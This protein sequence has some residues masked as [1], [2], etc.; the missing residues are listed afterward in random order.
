MHTFPALNTRAVYMQ[1]NTSAISPTKLSDNPRTIENVSN[2]T[3]ER[4]LPIQTETSLKGSKETRIFNASSNLP[5]YNA[6][7]SSE[8]LTTKFKKEILG[9]SLDI[10]Y[11]LPKPLNTVFAPITLESFLKT[12]A[13]VIKNKFS[14]DISRINIKGNAIRELAGFDYF[15]TLLKEQNVVLDTLLT[16]EELKAVRNTFEIKAPRSIEVVVYLRKNENKKEVLQKLQDLN[17]SIFQMLF[18]SLKTHWETIETPEIRASLFE[19]LK[20]KNSKFEYFDSSKPIFF[21]LIIENFAFSHYETQ[22]G[23]TPLSQIGFSNPGF[24]LKVQTVFTNETICQTPEDFYQASIYVSS[25]SSSDTKVAFVTPLQKRFDV[26]QCFLGKVIP[27]FDIKEVIYLWGHFIA[28]LQKGYIPAPDLDLPGLRNKTLNPLSDSLKQNKFV[29]IKPE[30]IQ[31]KTLIDHLRSTCPE[32]KNPKKALLLAIQT[33]FMEN[34]TLTEAEKKMVLSILSVH[35]TNHSLN[36]ASVWKIFSN[37]LSDPSFTFATFSSTLQITHLILWLTQQKK[38]QLHGIKNLWLDSTFAGEQ[39]EPLHLLHAFDPIQAFDSLLKSVQNESSSQKAFHSLLLALHTHRIKEY[40]SKTDVLPYDQ[41]QKNSVENTFKSLLK[42]INKGIYSSSELIF[43]LSYDLLLAVQR[44]KVVKSD[45]II[46]IENFEKR[47]ISSTESSSQFV[48]QELFECFKKSTWDL[49]EEDLKS[50]FDILQKNTTEENFKKSI[51]QWMNALSKLR[52]GD[53]DK[54]LFQLWSKDTPFE[55]EFSKELFNQFCL[56]DPDLAYAMLHKLLKKPLEVQEQVELILFFTKHL[57]GSTDAHIMRHLLFLDSLCER[58]RDVWALFLDKIDNDLWKWFLEQKN[59]KTELKQTLI[60]LNQRFLKNASPKTL[61]QK[62]R[63]LIE[64]YTSESNLPEALKC[65]EFLNCPS[66]HDQ[67]EPFNEFFQHLSIQLYQER[68]GCL[69]AKEPYPNLLN[70]LE[71][72]HVETLKSK[73]LK[74]VLVDLKQGSGQFLSEENKLEVLRFFL[75]KNQSIIESQLK[76]IDLCLTCED[77]IRKMGLNALQI[78]FNNFFVK[79]TTT[80]KQKQLLWDQLVKYEY[81][82]VIAFDSDWLQLIRAYIEAHS[83]DDLIKLYDTSSWMLEILI[84]S[85]TEFSEKYFDLLCA[86]FEKSAKRSKALNAKIQECF[87]FLLLELLKKNPSQ[88][89]HLFKI[90]SKEDFAFINS[91]SVR[92]QLKNSLPSLKSI[93]LNFETLQKLIWQLVESPQDE[94]SQEFLKQFVESLIAMKKHPDALKTILTAQPIN[95]FLSLFFTALKKCKMPKEH[96]TV[97]KYIQQFH[98]LNITS[99]NQTFEEHLTLYIKEIEPNPKEYALKELLVWGE[100]FCD[101]HKY[102]KKYSS[103]LV[104]DIC[105]KIIS[106]DLQPLEPKELNVVFKM[107]QTFEFKDAQLWIDL[108]IKCKNPI[109]KEAHELVK[110][111]LLNV[112]QIP[113]L[114]EL[115]PAIDFWD[116]AFNFLIHHAPNSCIDLLKDSKQSTLLVPHLI[117]QPDEIGKKFYIACCHT[118]KKTSILEIRKNHIVIIDRWRFLASHCIYDMGSLPQNSFLFD[119]EVLKA[120]SEALI[121]DDFSTEEEL[122]FAFTLFHTLAERILIHNFNSINWMGHAPTKDEVSSFM[123]VNT[124]LIPFQKYSQHVLRYN[125]DP[126]IVETQIQNDCEELS[127]FGC[128]LFRRLNDHKQEVLKNKNLFIFI[129]SYA[130]NF[131]SLIPLIKCMSEQLLDLKRKK[132]TLSKEYKDLINDII[133][134][135]F[136]EIKR[137]KQ[138]DDLFNVLTKEILDEIQDFLE[139]KKYTH[140]LGT[141]WHFCLCFLSMQNSHASS[142]IFISRHLSFLPLYAIHLNILNVNELLFDVLQSCFQAEQP[143]PYIS[144]IL[145]HSL[146]SL[147][148]SL[149]KIEIKINFENTHIYQLLEGIFIPIEISLFPEKIVGFQ[150][151]I[152]KAIPDLSERFSNFIVF[153]DYAMNCS[154]TGYFNSLANQKSYLEHMVAV[155]TTI[156]KNSAVLSVTPEQKESF[157]NAFNKLLALIILA[158]DKTLLNKT[159]SLSDAFKGCNFLKDNFSGKGFV[160]KCESEALFDFLFYRKCEFKLNPNEL[161]PHYLLKVFHTL[162]KQS[163]F[164]EKRKKQTFN[165]MVDQSNDNINV[166]K[167]HELRVWKHS[168]EF[169]LTHLKDLTENIESFE[170]A[171]KVLYDFL[172]EQSN[173]TFSLFTAEFRQLNKTLYSELDHLLLTK[174]D[175]NNLVLKYKKSLKDISLIFFD[176]GVKRFAPKGDEITEEATKLTLY[177]VGSTG[178]GILEAPLDVEVHYKMLDLLISLTL[179]FDSDHLF[180]DQYIHFEDVVKLILLPVAE[181][182]EMYVASPD[183]SKTVLRR[184]LFTFQTYFLGLLKKAKNKQHIE[185]ITNKFEEHFKNLLIEKRSDLDA[186]NLDSNLTA[187]FDSY[188]NL[189]KLFYILHKRQSEIIGD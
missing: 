43:Q 42:L 102:S 158:D 37:I 52:C 121:I 85:R 87:D 101:I 47:L 176:N 4:S 30:E 108:L 184:R 7:V 75:Q 152:Q 155:L 125:A 35:W 147:F 109:P 96:Q 64:K 71:S 16:T 114:N 129:S 111:N 8:A 13:L 91:K 25:L 163:W 61:N 50:A 180:S 112:L 99:Q 20:K 127:D 164:L 19:E 78:S 14:Q 80:S 110:E 128:L 162:L 18:S 174:L 44:F 40:E 77:K 117:A 74:E 94:E 45:L 151:I 49:P 76:I 161:P 135:I 46:L 181:K 81:K 55:F 178:L 106:Q 169:F 146:E 148:H 33:C 139:L 122:F 82:N 150:K 3:E 104:F 189:K 11:H 51:H 182:L 119:T 28:T 15:Q 154:K 23:L 65:L 1:T 22:E 97:I 69:L 145:T 157:L 153:F 175:D 21:D 116:F 123:P 149:Q 131:D 137:N 89:F 84:T 113:N 124:Q 26:I 83:L 41:N 141:L 118:A 136:S 167:Q 171:L 144:F 12:Y 100:F 59:Q 133:F 185:A 179:K 27:F 170:I 5:S 58:R 60:E 57:K 132:E 188:D 105:K 92:L 168:R 159:A 130:K 73:K 66:D 103:T 98:S 115:R 6:L 9:H 10:Y 126:N 34:K 31:T 36:T 17:A 173:Q 187:L 68:K 142:E 143:K 95:P 63:L 134:A 62:W 172:L 166:A 90:L 48:T 183:K 67:E 186:E 107:F 2:Q 56:T 72:L 53:L 79:L 160:L 70:Y 39:N 86:L 32:L 138:N 177:Q 156:L 93:D 29:Q 24:N 38:V 140:N 54:I 120:H 165:A 88:F